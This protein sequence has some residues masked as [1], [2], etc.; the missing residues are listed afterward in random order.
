LSCAYFLSKAGLKV[1]VIEKDSIGSHASGF[2]YG[3]LSPL[4]EAGLVDEIVT[5][6]D[7]AK[8]GMEIHTRFS[9]DLPNETGIDIQHRFRPAM[10]LAFTDSEADV[11]KSQVAWRNS[12]DGYKAEWIEGDQARTLI[13]SLSGDIIGA[14]ITEGVADVDPYRLI[15]ALTQ[16]CEKSGVE[17]KHGL[18]SNLKE[19]QGHGLSINTSFGKLQ[20]ETA[21]IAMGPWTKQIE[22]WVGCTVPIQPLKGQIIRLDSPGIEVNFSVGWEGNYACT[23]LDGLLWAGTTE[24]HAGFDENTT[25]QARNQVMASLLRMLPGLDEAKLVQQTA[26]LRPLAK[27]GKVILGRIDNYD[28]VYIATGAGRKGILLGPAMGQ[29]ISDLVTTGITKLNLDNFAL[30]RF[31]N[32]Y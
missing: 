16:A 20:C 10:D 17:I 22:N 8:L 21:I 9:E 25:Y 18:F 29:T 6:L 26:C 14:G 23:K 19:K 32:S 30:S 7:L 12:Q 3:S 1:I 27:D 4:G 5:E 11:C 2:A 31:S 13:P 28:H 24:E 15:L